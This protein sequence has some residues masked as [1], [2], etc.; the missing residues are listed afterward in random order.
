MIEQ[1]LRVLFLAAEATPF[2]KIGGLGD[3][4]GTLPQALRALP[5]APDVR[6]VLPLHAAINKDDYALSPVAAFNIAYSD[7]PMRAEVFETVVDGL[8]VYLIAGTPITADAPV[9]SPDAAVDG[10]KYTFFSLAALELA[11]ILS[12]QPEIVHAQDWHAAPAVYAVGMRRAQDVYYRQT[13]TLLTVHNLPYLG[14]GA[15]DALRAFGLPAAEHSTLPDWAWH[16]PLPLGLLS[17][18][19][20]NTVSPGYAAELLTPEFGSGLHDFLAT[21]QEDISGILNGLDMTVWDPH[22]DSH[23]PVNYDQSELAER[24]ENKRWLQDELNFAVNPSIPLLSIV[25]RMDSQKG[26]DLALA[27]LRLVAERPWRLVILGTGDPVLEEQAR[28]LGRE[29]PN[30]VRILMRFDEGLARRIYA[31]A[32][33]I[34]IPSRYEPCGLTQ[35]I[36]MRYGCV[37]IGRAVGGLRDTIIDYDADREEST[38][39]LFTEAA[40]EALAAAI[41]RA[42]G[43]FFEKRA[44]RGL[45]MRGMREDFS[46]VLSAEKYYALYQSIMTAKF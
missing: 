46:W 35:M 1:N 9:Y 19:K 41:E 17:A 27:G 40:P 8:P 11:R 36:G 30:R 39:F 33:M 16:M 29:F 20:I 34:L 15:Q 2:V 23:L 18:D 5:A 28:Q 7:G 14:N 25:S 22:N 10:V 13:G 38:G 32:D 26:I 37:P 45:Q 43:V 21:R 6:L 42:L 3:V 4:A 44:W 31:G 24:V 12:W